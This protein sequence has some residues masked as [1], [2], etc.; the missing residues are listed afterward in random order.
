MAPPG[1]I[2]P[3]SAKFRLPEPAEAGSG[4]FLPL[5]PFNAARAGA[6]ALPSTPAPL[7]GGSQ[8][9]PARCIIQAL[10]PQG[11]A[12][13]AVRPAAGGAQGNAAGEVTK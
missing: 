2:P 3:V 6:V 11:S 5:C 10:I 7:R 13:P 1:R 9:A 12:A 4:S 8:P